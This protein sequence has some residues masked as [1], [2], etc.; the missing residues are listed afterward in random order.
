[1]EQAIQYLGSR[2]ELVV[3]RVEDLPF[4][5]VEGMRKL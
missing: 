5:I 1:M 2:R 3:S 4:D